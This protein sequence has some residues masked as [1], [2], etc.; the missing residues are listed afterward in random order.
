MY[1]AFLAAAGITVV[2]IDDDIARRAVAAFDA[3]GKGRGHPAQL[4]FADCLSYACAAH[5]RVAILFKGRDFV[6]TDLDIA[7]A[8]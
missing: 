1:D 5:G 3:Y 2:A 7:S 6:H 8:G 4:N